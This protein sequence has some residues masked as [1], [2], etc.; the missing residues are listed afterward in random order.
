MMLWSKAIDFKV[1]S[2]DTGRSRRRH[3]GFQ[4]AIYVPLWMHWPGGGLF[5]WVVA[6]R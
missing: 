1:M 4:R 2:L 6:V 3:V 5:D